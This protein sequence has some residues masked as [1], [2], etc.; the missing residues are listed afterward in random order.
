MAK[1]FRQLQIETADRRIVLGISDDSRLVQ[2]D[3]IFLAR[4]GTVKNGADYV[5]EAL[6]KGAVVLWE[7]ENAQNCYH[8]EDIAKA[9]EILLRSFYEDPSRHLQ[10]IGVTGTNAKTSVSNLLAQML[11][12]LDRKV[13]VIGTGA[14]RFL[15]QEIAIDNTTPSACMLAYYFHQAILHDISTIIMEVSSHAIDQNRICFIRFDAVIYTNIASDHLDYHITRTHYQYTKLKLRNY[16]KR[17]GVLIVN[18]DDESLHPL[19]SLDDHK[20]VTVG[21][22]Q[23]HL[24]ISEMEL[25]PYGSSFC[26]ENIHYEMSLLGIHNVYNVGQCLVILHEMNIEA[27][28]RQR[29]VKSLHAVAGRMEFH[30]IAHTYAI[31]DYAHTASSLSAL[32]ETVSQIK[33]RRMIVIC[34]C[35]GN[36]DRLK[37]KEMAQVALRYGDIAIFTTDNPRQEAPYQILYDMTQGLIGSYE[38][39]ENRFCAIKYAV[40]IAQEHDIIVIAGK[41]NERFQVFFDKKYPF[42]DQAAL[43]KALEEIHYES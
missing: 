40:K 16:L 42:S 43:R 5:Q 31:I 8:C 36:R 17:N 4:R 23:A 13:M 38:I 6:S 37:R 18:H 41:G 19:Y 30:T 3:W 39:F 33:E 28:K 34:G 26:L 14:I 12:S 27:E 22:K 25:K 29:I 20:V 24:Q 35:G 2:K 9:Q 7:K 32:L 1:L 11:E 21:V 15:D 10:V